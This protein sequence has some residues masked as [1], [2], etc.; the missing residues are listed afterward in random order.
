MIEQSLINDH[1]CYWVNI[2]W[3]VLPPF[4]LLFVGCLSRKMDWLGQET[5]KSL[6]LV[7]H[8]CT[9]SMLHYLYVLNAETLVKLDE[10]FTG[11]LFG[12]FQLWLDF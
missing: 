4:L 12:F 5:E 10:A 1:L 9:L 8:P 2:I 6:S 7:Y 3:A 11:A